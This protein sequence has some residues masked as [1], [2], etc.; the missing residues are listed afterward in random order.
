MAAFNGLEYIASNADLR[1]AFGAN[2]A[3]GE[4][5]YANSGTREGR[6]VAFDTLDYIAS[7]TH[8]ITNGVREGRKAD[9]FDAAQYLDN[10]PDLQAVFGEDQELATLATPTSH[11]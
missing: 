1:A 10:Y 5:H 11:K 7:A 8:Y 4:A 3:A 9:T 2:K 6:A